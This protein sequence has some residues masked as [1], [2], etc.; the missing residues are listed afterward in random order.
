MGAWARGST[1]RWRRTR[2]HALA[3]NGRTNG[4]RCAVA[5]NGS[6]P[7]PKHP[8]RRCA[9][10]TG[11]ANTVHHTRGRAVTGDDPRFLLAS[12]TPCNL[13]IGE[14]DTAGPQPSPVTKW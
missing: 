11:K 6:R 2:A 9:P 3:E 7:C 10:C 12:C 8:Q 1:R 13:H 4:G 14:P 5:L